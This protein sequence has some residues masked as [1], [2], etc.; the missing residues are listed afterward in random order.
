MI[1]IVQDKG[2]FEYDIELYNENKK[3]IYNKQINGELN[4]D[5]NPKENTLKWV[6]FTGNSLT[7]LMLRFQSFGVGTNLQFLLNKCLFENNRKESLE[8]ALT[9]DELQYASNFL[10]QDQMEIEEEN[11]APFSNF[12][13]LQIDDFY[14]NYKQNDD[15]KNRTFSQAK[16]LDRTFLSKGSIIN[17]FKTEE[18]NDDN[19]E[20]NLII[21]FNIKINLFFFLVHL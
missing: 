2:D 3:K 1:F 11:I 17:V 9:K 5:L 10:A 21:N 18:D 7:L 16:L 20:V 6:D 15:L 8:H 19:I 13:D 4:F 14:S 12:P